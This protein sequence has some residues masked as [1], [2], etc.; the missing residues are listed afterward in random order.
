MNHPID[1][2]TDFLNFATNSMLLTKKLYAFL[3][4]FSKPLVAIP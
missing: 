1:V 2:S 3:T 4:E